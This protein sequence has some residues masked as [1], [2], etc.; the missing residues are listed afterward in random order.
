MLFQSILSLNEGNEF[1]WIS[2]I[3][4]IYSQ[5]PGKH[6]SI[7]ASLRGAWS[8]GYVM[9]TDPEYNIYGANDTLTGSYKK[10]FKYIGIGLGVSYRL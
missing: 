8:K 7:E 1:R 10:Q 9:R 3:G 4:L 6:I 2:D 5:R